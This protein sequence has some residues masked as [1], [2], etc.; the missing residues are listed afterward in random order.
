MADDRLTLEF[1]V[2][3]KGGIR[4]LNKVGTALDKTK[5]KTKQASLGVGGFG[6]SLGKVAAL[7]AG[8]FGVTSAL[9]AM[10]RAAGFV[11]SSSIEMNAS[12]EKAALQ[13]ETFT[14]S[15]E[16]AEAHVRSLFDFAKSTPFESGPIIEASRLMRT[17]GGD[18][19]D[20]EANLRLI[21]DASAATSAPI[22]ELGMWTGR[23]FAA[24]Q[25]GQPIGEATLRMMELGVV[26][27]QVVT[28]M[29]AMREAGAS[30]MEVFAE[31]Q[32]ALG[33][34]T[35]SMEKQ[36][37]TWE[38]LTSTFWES[39]KIMIANNTVG[40]FNLLKSAIQGAID[41]MDTINKGPMARAADQL[42]RLVAA[43]N[44][45]GESMV[46]MGQTM[47]D[48]THQQ[49]FQIEQRGIL[50]TAILD[51]QRAQDAAT[52]AAGEAVPVIEDNT[53][54]LE[55]AEKAA[56][57]FRES[58]DRV[59]GAQQRSLIVTQNHI[60][61][62]QSLGSTYRDEAATLESFAFGLDLVGVRLQAVG[63]N[64]DDVRA[65][66]GGFF[67][68][69]K[70][71]FSSMM[72]GLTGGEGFSGFLKGLGGGIVE[73]FGNIISG[74][75]TSIINTGFSLIGKGISKLFSIG[76]PSEAE[77][78]GRESAASFREG[79]AASGDHAGFLAGIQEEFIRIGF[80]AEEA[81]AKARAF[82]V[83]LHAAERQGPE[84][85][86]AVIDRFTAQSEAFD[87]QI[88][89]L[90]EMRQAELDLAAVQAERAALM[91]ETLA[92]GAAAFAEFADSS[93][94][95]M[96]EVPAAFEPLIRQTE[97]LTGEITGPLIRA[98]KAG[99]VALSSLNTTGNLTGK[100]FAQTG[101]GIKAAFHR[102][103]AE[104]LT[105]EEAMEALREPIGA[106]ALAQEKHGLKTDEGTQ[107]LIDQA[108]Q[109]GITAA[110]GETAA[111]RQIAAMDRMILKLEELLVFFEETLP[112][113]IRN[114]PDV[115]IE[116]NVSGSSGGA[117]AAAGGGE[118]PQYLA[119]GG[120]ARGTDT[121]SAMLTPGEFVLRR[122]AVKKLGLGRV[123]ELN[124]GIDRPGGVTVNVDL[125]GAVVANDAARRDLVS[126]IGDEL[127]QRVSL[128]KRLNVAVT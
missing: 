79:F 22:N 33:Q 8:V 96:V 27:P 52:L 74:G 126:D 122:G 29:R 118:V 28:K 69:I 93:I 113:A 18:L 17:F 45:A 83:A 109:Y 12:I 54:A 121:V 7:G 99:G 25:G 43:Q 10:T 114:L 59:N 120:A 24:L 61:A 1:V 86:Q 30:G 105:A 84:A 47:D 36:A 78:A 35:G 64:F 55:A 94:G 116:T 23:L 53:A 5:A 128:R 49:R 42:D 34:F 56:K 57:E 41:V 19:L 58:V 82:G 87:A 85:V 20:T 4:V 103:V 46:R 67:S 76:G 32:G 90:A 72:E 13:F 38:G 112:E 123:S 9:S 65:S 16:T 117:V 11:V 14:G 95:K 2:D 31:F 124:E 101:A 71:G 100:T 102:L 119:R 80:G 21:G 50:I 104:G 111:D 97:I 127:V 60:R 89:Q 63:R 91:E 115:E 88:A 110:D 75:L 37:S 77:L 107:H 70:E 73:G 26:T 68:G 125:R 15:A 81:G 98:A 6:L 92:T 51:E 106:L 40:A 39:A 66:S 62:V 3:D 48:L 108:G 44:A